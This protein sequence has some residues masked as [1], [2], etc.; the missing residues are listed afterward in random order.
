MEKHK[1]L[2]LTESPL[3][4]FEEC[5]FFISS[6][7]IT[8]GEFI[9]GVMDNKNILRLIQFDEPQKVQERLKEKKQ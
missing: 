4:S 9:Q 1:T 3:L 2:D 7:K 6:G 5:I 8:E